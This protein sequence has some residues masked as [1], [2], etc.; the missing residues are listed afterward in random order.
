MTQIYITIGIIAV[1]AILVCYVF[2]HQTIGNRRLEKERLQ[3]ALSKRAKELLQMAS[4]FPENFLPKE[5]LVFIYRCIIDAFE[6]LTKL[7]PSDGQFI[8]ALKLHSLQLETVIRKPETSKTVELHS[9]TQINELRQYLN[10]LGAFLQKSMERN[11]ITPKQYSHYRHLLKE[12]IVKLA[13]NNYMIAAKQALETQKTKLSIHYYDL[14][15]KLLI[16]ETPS[17]Y[18]EAL[19]KITIALEPLLQM[20]QIERAAQDNDEPS[21]NAAAKVTN[22]K[23]EWKD[24]EDKGD[25]KKKNVYD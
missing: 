15:K 24:F 8:D 9:I 18:K 25:W 11:H 7:N 20:E 10:L 5:L 1:I 23:D 21:S 22:D 3:R 12:V 17:H 13:V 19:E 6:Q 4:A 2:I 16:K 14:A